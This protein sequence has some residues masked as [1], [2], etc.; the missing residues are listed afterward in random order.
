MKI[1]LV[2]LALLATAC[3]QQSDSGEPPVKASAP[4][5]PAVAPTS[6]DPS[7][8]D[9]MQADADAADACGASKVAPW[10]GKESTVPVRSAVAKASGAASDRWIYPDSVVT[11][12]FRPDRLNVVMEHGTDKIVSAHCG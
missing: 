2:S 10:I 8:A 6:D 4:A 7:Q 1:C 11:Q 3:T 5:A 9:R 12:D